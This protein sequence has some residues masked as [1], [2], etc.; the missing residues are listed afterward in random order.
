[1]NIKDMLCNPERNAKKHMKF[2]LNLS[3]QY[4]KKSGL[5]MPHF[6]DAKAILDNPFVIESAH[7]PNFLPSINYF[8]KIL[9][10]NNLANNEDTIFF[11][12]FLDTDT[13][14][15][16]WSTTNILPFI[17]KPGYLSFGFPSLKGIKKP[18]SLINKPSEKDFDIMIGSIAKAYSNNSLKTIKGKS[19]DVSKNKLIDVLRRAYEKAENLGQLNS[20]MCS[21]ILGEIFN[22]YPFYYLFSDIT[23]NP[24]FYSYFLYFFDN[25][26]TI[27][28]Q[29]ALISTSSKSDLNIVPLWFHCDC[30][31]KLKIL[32]KDEDNFISA[33]NKCS[34][35]YTINK[36][37]IKKNLF[38]FS[39]NYL[40]RALLVSQILGTDVYITGK[41]GVDPASGQYEVTLQHLARKLNIPL[42]RLLVLDTN[43]TYPGIIYKNY[44]NELA[45][46]GLNIK[47]LGPEIK[48]TENQISFYKQ[49]LSNSDSS[50]KKELSK[51]NSK[52]IFLRFNQSGR[53][54]ASFID[55][56]ITYGMDGVKAVIDS[57]L[58]DYTFSCNSENAMHFKLGNNVDEGTKQ[59]S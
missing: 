17:N 4:Y 10:G 20:F 31:N 11:H 38:R 58:A 32:K 30:G 1:M 6:N 2:F 33:C 16:K 25:C 23:G 19:W 59:N 9:L 56:I 51:L 8:A 53:I 12:G 26:K 45:L 35:G 14:S 5:Y 42:Y 13:T 28:E 21:N 47:K 49:S 22:I 36:E 29:T 39:V 48:K 54:R 52:L 27:N 15:E 44:I 46:R 41:G 55:V 7:Q 50:E 37:F 43:F 18:F 24:E 57:L 40:T 34:A 3:R